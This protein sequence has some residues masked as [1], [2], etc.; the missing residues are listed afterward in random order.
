MPSR[1]TLCL[2][3]P[4]TPDNPDLILARTLKESVG[5]GITISRTA[6]NSDGKK[7]DG[8]VAIHIPDP[9]QR[10]C[11]QD[12]HQ[13]PTMQVLENTYWT[14][15]YLNPDG[16]YLNSL[17]YPLKERLLAYHYHR[18][19]KNHPYIPIDPA[20]T[21]TISGIEVSQ[22]SFIKT[23]HSMIFREI[24]SLVFSN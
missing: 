10:Q 11:F 2:N 15:N 7:L 5:F 17:G 8:C 23:A 12:I 18:K 24:V 6:T 4:N 22:G 14:T 21:K 9:E 13:S 19:A 3:T 16:D 20:V 1:E